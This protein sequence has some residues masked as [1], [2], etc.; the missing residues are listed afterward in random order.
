MKPVLGR[1]L[2]SLIP[3]KKI[4]SSPP[5]PSLNLPVGTM[6]IDIPIETIVPNSHQPRT[7]FAPEELNDLVESVK[8]HGILLPLVVTRKDDG[9]ELIAGERRLRAAK[10]AGFSTVPAL[11]RDAN[12]QQKLE[13]ALIENIQRQDLNVLEEATAFRT[14]I[15]EFDLTQEEVAKRVGKSR[16]VVAN[17]LRLLELPEFMQ[18]ALREG[19]ISKSHARTLLSESDPEKQRA[20]FEAMIRGEVTVRAAEHSV[21]AHQRSA[22]GTR[23]G[24]PNLI[25]YERQLQEQFGTKVEIR[26]QKGKG[27]ITFHFYSK[28]DLRE[29]LR[30]FANL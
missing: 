15:N 28:D 12:E 16:S 30:R 7:Y 27:N 21:S 11:V 2:G 1:G 4:L 17:T 26:E 20:L 25:D 6:V 10:L 18:Q 23:R 22:P 9:Y 19:K 3:Q 8:A 29:L 5:S 13:L 24:D 14:F